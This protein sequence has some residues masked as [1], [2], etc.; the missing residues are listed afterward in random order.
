MEYPERVN[1]TEPSEALITARS[2]A[3]ERGDFEVVKD[4]IAH[5]TLTGMAGVASLMLQ[6]TDALGTVMADIDGRRP[7]P[8]ADEVRS[9]MNLRPGAI[10]I[11]SD[12]IAKTRAFEW[13]EALN[14]LRLSP[15]GSVAG[16]ARHL[17]DFG[18]LPTRNESILRRGVRKVRRET[19]S[20]VIRLP[21]GAMDLASVPQIQLF[22]EISRWWALRVGEAQEVYDFADKQLRAHLT[23]GDVVADLA[24][25]A[26]TELEEYRGQTDSAQ[27]ELV[28]VMEETRSL[29]PMEIE[30]VVEQHAANVRGTELL[31]LQAQLER[32]QAEAAIKLMT[33]T[34]AIDEA[35]RNM[36]SRHVKGLAFLKLQLSS[37]RWL[38][39]AE[40]GL[41]VTL[42]ATYTMLAGA[43]AQVVEARAG[44]LHQDITLYEEILPDAV[45]SAM[46]LTNGHIRLLRTA[47]PDGVVGS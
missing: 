3:I 45:G 28:R 27:V 18:L 29:Q 43:L 10:E 32:K 25:K 20:L 21:E 15:I 6:A 16:T 46:G 11:F 34:L 4:L 38:T 39:S 24:D 36:D 37:L 19:K 44:C 35:L 41:K 7:Q 9:L 12:F 17:V 14:S 8:I 13:I 47:S 40:R 26:R 5:E 42:G 2:R 30:G 33:A 22:F 1:P 31:R 23:E